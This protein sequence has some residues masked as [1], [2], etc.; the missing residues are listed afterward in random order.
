MAERGKRPIPKSQRKISEELQTPY[1]N[2]ETG[3][4]RGNPNDAFLN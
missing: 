3:E 1:R 4:T 2:P